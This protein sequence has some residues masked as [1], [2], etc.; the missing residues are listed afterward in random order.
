[1]SA[2]GASVLGMNGACQHSRSIRSLYATLA[3]F[4]VR[5]AAARPG[6]TT[7][8]AGRAEPTSSV[9]DDARLAGDLSASMS[10][11]GLRH[12]GGNAPFYS[13]TAA[14]IHSRLRHVCQVR[15]VRPLLA[16]DWRVTRRRQAHTLEGHLPQAWARNELQPRAGALELAAR[17]TA[18]CGA[19][20]NLA[21]TV[22]SLDAARCLRCASTMGSN[23]ALGPAGEAAAACDARTFGQRVGGSASSSPIGCISSATCTAASGRGGKGALGIETG[24]DRSPPAVACG[25]IVSRSRSRFRFRRR[26]APAPEDF[27]WRIGHETPF[28]GRQNDVVIDAHIQ[29]VRRGRRGDAPSDVVPT[30]VLR[31]SRGEH[32]SRRP[33]RKQ[34]GTVMR[35]P[36]W[37]IAAGGMT[38]T[39]LP[40]RPRAVDFS[41]SWVRHGGL[42]AV[43]TSRTHYQ[44]F[45]DDTRHVLARHGRRSAGGRQVCRQVRR[46][47]AVQARAR[48]EQRQRIQRA[49]CRG[50]SCLGARPTIGSSARASSAFR[51]TFTRRPYDVGVTYDFARLPTE[52]YSIVA[53]Q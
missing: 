42:C 47:G 9:A 11:S 34:A 5:A 50:R 13:A 14:S 52:M 32:G 7:L 18:S 49:P 15:R 37:G 38:R 51:S 6:P 1:M 29:H 20:S 16:G 21:T 10:H 44:R 26:S 40:F 4:R 8:P 31:R 3:E 41:V 17:A 46:D 35:Y 43:R 33:I 19:R 12:A 45:I 25:V 22:E 28:R 53:E 30:A 23:R 36:V 2:S 27:D 39:W 24:G 48:L